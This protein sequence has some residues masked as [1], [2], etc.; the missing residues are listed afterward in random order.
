MATQDKKV[1]RPPAPKVTISNPFLDER[2]ELIKQ[3]EKDNPDFVYMCQREDI[4]ERKLK[5]L[6][7]EVVT[8]PDGNKVMSHG[9]IVVKVP[10]AVWE[11]KQLIEGERSRQMIESIVDNDESTVF[12]SAKKPLEGKKRKK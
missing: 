11:E 3:L 6:S 9:D 1:E 10:R 7:Q 12:A 8:D 5:Q 2:A 4:P